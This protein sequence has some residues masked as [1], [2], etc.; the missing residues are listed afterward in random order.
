MIYD[1]FFD[2]FFV[3]FKRMD[4]VRVKVM[5]EHRI[6]S[7]FARI[8]CQANNLFLVR[9]DIYSIFSCLQNVSNNDLVAIIK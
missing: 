7:V 3:K 6:W 1:R 8:S 5:Q 9:D 4:R 2:I